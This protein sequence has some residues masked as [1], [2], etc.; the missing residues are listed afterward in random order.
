MKRIIS[1]I[2]LA[3]SF[4][5]T[6]TLLAQSPAA[7]EA[8]NNAY[9]L[10][11]AGNYQEAAAAYEKLLKDFPTDGLVPSAQIQLG[12]AYYFLGRFDDAMAIVQKA[13]SGPTLPAELKQAADNLIPQILSAKAAAMDAGDPRRKT[14]FEE[15]I[16]KFTDYITAYPQADDLESA[17]YS[18]AV[19]NYQI[20]NYDETVKDCEL[21]M[22]RFP[23][24]PALPTTKNLLAITLATQG[25]QK[26][27]QG[28]DNAAA[29]ALYDRAAGLLREIIG[30]RKDI[31]LF[32]DA[33][34]QLGEI[35]FNQAAFSADDQ[36]S[37]L[38]AQALDAYRSIIPQAEVLAFQEDLIVT[39]PEKR[40]AAI[41]ARNQALLKQLE[42][43]N[44]RELTKL[45]Q[46]KNKP[47]PIAGAMLKM[48]E[49]YFQ[50]GNLNASRTLL[51]HI[52]PFLKQAD[53]AKRKLY[54]TTMS[55]ALQGKTDNALAGYKEFQ[56]AYKGDPLAEN[57]PVAIGNML[58]GQ[59]KPADAIQ[60]FNESLTLYPKGRF[61]GLSVVSKASAEA[62]L[63]QHE[64][65][66]KTFKD[67]LAT[68]PPP[69]VAVIA[70]AGLANIY[71]DTAKWD[72]ALA[73]Y[74]K[75]KENFPGTPQAVEADYWI[76]ICT[77]Q[78]GDNT[79]AIPLLSAFV[80]AHPEHPLAPLA[81]YAKGAAEL[82]T[83]KPEEGIAS[84]AAVAEKYPD[85]QPAPFT[86]FMRA[87]LR[88]AAGNTEEVI[89]LM[90]AFIEKYPKDDK[91]FP[92]YES[93]A[94][95]ELNQGKTD[96][97][98]ATFREYVEK[99]SD[100]PQ[101]ADALQRLADIQIKAAEHLGRYGALNE[102]ERAKWTTAMEASIASSEQLLKQYPESPQLALALRSL[103][104]A[105]RA[106]VSA[107]IKTPEDTE[108]Y[109]TQL[110][111]SAPSPKA[112]SKVLF[113]LAD[114]VA[115][116]NP[117]RALEIMKSAYDPQ[118]VYAPA[119][120]DSYGLALVKKGSLDDAAKVFAKLASDYPNPVGTAPTQAPPL[121]QEAQAIALFGQAS[122]AQKQ[123]NTAEAG[124]LFEQ[125]KTLY[126]WSP[127]VLEANYGIAD[128][129]RG[130][131]KLDEAMGLL[132]SII[133]ASTATAELRANSML[134]FGH[135]MATKST[136][137]TD[138]KQ[139]RQFLD[140]A[141][142]NFIKIPQFYG[143]VPQAAA[144][145]L[146]EG[147]SLL[148]K[149]AGG[150]TDAAFKKQQLGRARLFYTQLV[151]Q[152]P[153]SPFTAKAKERLS[154]LPAQ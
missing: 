11:S 95:A 61:A 122:V 152:Y 91:V 102:E 108:K 126:P 12:F 16:K 45:E 55:Y 23:Q 89:A 118:V 135:I 27:N 106:M 41:Q 17:I 26:L 72:D 24:S 8:N 69:D 100:T 111:E 113:A 79:A 10:F 140:S 88:G 97:A 149:Q 77:Q 28:G 153:D 62:A 35:L 56:A 86:Y 42:K 48:A 129:L 80:T 29:F 75:V 137:A 21:A 87:Q 76:G 117:D 105:R 84:L 120:L 22:Q 123:G 110:A 20:G 143:G 112:K 43:D 125:L 59:G 14:T 133:R 64:S 54:F 82:A 36:K 46:L 34:F 70:Q 51:R 60:Y 93:I 19:A 31:A 2:V 33:N 38:F 18:R 83:N 68:N 124:K 116:S 44:L 94:M 63:A 53:E 13:L 6:H 103:L 1:A 25:S 7:A 71:K 136:Q 90:K 109:F 150:S 144:E 85:S 141:I 115:T 15:A 74:A 132:G 154:A 32:N 138:P 30:N 5:L 148:E 142:D 98:L 114:Y 81:L 104:Q 99:Y 131:G 9:N 121:V 146:W 66:A 151:E 134:M 67:F 49:I 65:A 57:L 4:L 130:Q 78:K 58:L 3:T 119:D 52:T 47:D 107:G 40:R 128:A 145:G 37:K 96:Q 139:Q 73:A 127:K 39:F 147:A 92:A 101:A 50:Q